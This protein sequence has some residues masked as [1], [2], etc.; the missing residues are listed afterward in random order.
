MLKPLLIWMSGNVSVVQT[1][2]SD[3]S[4]FVFIVEQV[5]ASQSLHVRGLCAHVVARSLQ[6]ASAAT[7]ELPMDHDGLLRVIKNIGMEKFVE[8]LD[9][10][11]GAPEVS[12]ALTQANDELSGLY[13]PWFAR[14]LGK[15]TEEVKQCILQACTQGALSG[16][17]RAASPTP[18]GA[19]SSGDSSEV[20]DMYKSIIRQQDEQLR[21]VNEQLDAFRASEAKTEAHNNGQDVANT[22]MVMKAHNTRLEAQLTEVSREAEGAKEALKRTEAER[23]SLEV[24]VLEAEG[25]VRTAVEEAQ[26]LSITFNDL[27]EACFNKDEQLA[28]M[29][30]AFNEGD[31]EMPVPVQDLGVELTETRVF[32]EGL[33]KS[34]REA[35]DA[36]AC[37]Q[38]EHQL[39]QAE[40][41]QLR[42]QVE[43]LQTQ[44]EAL[45]QAEDA[46]VQEAQGENLPE[47]GHVN[48]TDEVV[49]LQQEI[50]SQTQSNKALRAEL[51]DLLVCL[52]QICYQQQSLVDPSRDLC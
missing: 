24:R 44:V 38:K 45:Q 40:L 7:E 13:E 39:A 2:L 32:V 31:T 8:T 46:E 12:R 47:Q 52:G 37:A 19:A 5:T 34:R 25:Q 4:S 42:S 10:L 16:N 17:E 26:F 15:S 48:Q 35:E 23:S 6:A 21:A 14:K 51:N 11:N 9:L 43:S 27:Q 49:N 50:T 22:Y 3:T 30:R 36:A 41:K 33:Q 18:G 20:V 1:L 29:Q 28:E